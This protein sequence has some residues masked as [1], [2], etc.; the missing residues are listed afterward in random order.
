MFEPVRADPSRL[1]IFF[2]TICSKKWGKNEYLAIEIT[3]LIQAIIPY[4]NFSHQFT[5]RTPQ[6][7][8]FHH[9]GMLYIL[10]LKKKKEHFDPN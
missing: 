3:Q 2:L 4:I 10:P 6:N 9:E 8:K 7:V 1:Q 5:I